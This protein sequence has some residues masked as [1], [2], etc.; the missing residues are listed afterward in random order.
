[1]GLAAALGP[2]TGTASPSGQIT[3]LIPSTG[4]PI[5]VIGMGSWITFNVAGD[6]VALA[7]RTEVLRTFFAFGGG[8]IDSSPMYGS[9]E[10]VI[11]YCLKRLSSHFDLFSASKVWIAGKRLGVQQMEHSRK[12]WGLPRFDLLQIHNLLDWDTH[13]ETLQEWKRAGRVRYVGITTSHGRRHSEFE[14]I[15]ERAPIDFVQLTYNILDRDAERRLLPLARERGL[16]VVVNRPF[17]RGGLFRH[18]HRKTLPAWASE[19]DCHNWPQ[20]LLK[21]IISHPAVTCAIPATSRVDHMEQ[22]MGAAFGR[23]PSPDLRLRMSRHF[24]AL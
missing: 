24:E 11:G 13:L 12:L 3:R 14:R 7:V 6:R 8:L 22:N 15:M 17:R 5:P 18:V 4:E 9:S 23:L 2:R 1:M 20:F 10:Q 16:A 19:F 21:F